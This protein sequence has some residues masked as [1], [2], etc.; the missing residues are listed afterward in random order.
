MIDLIK[1]LFDLIVLLLSSSSK[2]AA[3]QAKTNPYGTDQTGTV[4]DDPEDDDDT[5]IKDQ[6]EKVIQVKQIEDNRKIFKEG[7]VLVL[8]YEGGFSNIPED[9]GGPTNKGI[10]Q[11]VYDA[12]RKSKSLPLQSVEFITDEE[13]EDIYYQRYWLV[14]VCDKMTPKLSIA[15]FDTAVNTGTKQAAKFLQRSL[16][17]KADGIIGPQTIEKLKTQDENAIIQNYLEQR[18][19]FYK[20]LAEK[21]PTLQKFLKGWLKRVDS[22]ESYL[23]AR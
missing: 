2:V 14:A 18:R 22:L 13:V 19:V 12:Y 3:S 5:M 10:I 4:I 23:N 6:Q 17:I 20:N 11:T 7:L 9:P 21:K 16:E 1:K 15:H 8:K